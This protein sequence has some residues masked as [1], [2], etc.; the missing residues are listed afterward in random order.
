[1]S[2][3]A[4]S[5]RSTRTARPR[6]RWMQHSLALFC[7][8]LVLA[9]WPAAPTQAQ[10]VPF[11]PA[12]CPIAALEGQ[13]I[14][15]GY[16]TVAE[17]RSNFTGRTIQLA[18][19]IVRSPNPNKAADPAVFLAGGPGQGAL[20]IAPIVARLYGPVLAQRDI[21]FVDQRGT[22]YSRPRLDCP[23]SLMM[24]GGRFPIGVYQDQERSGFVQQQV[25]QFKACGAALRSAGIDLSAY[26][27][28]E[29]A[30]D[31]ED[32]RLALGYGPWNLIGGS[33]GTRLALT[34]M[35]YRPETIRSA[36]LDSVYPLQANFHTEVFGSYNRA[37][38]LLFA[39][40]A[41]DA[42]C[43]A[44]FPNLD[45]AYDDVIARFNAEP[46][47]MPILNPET[48]EVLTTL[49]FT[50][51]DFSLII[52]QLAYSTEVIT[53][54]PALIT[55]TANGNYELMGAL[56]GSLFASQSGVS[57]V[58]AAMQVAV[59]C[60]EDAPFAEPVDFVAARDSN[61]RA[62]SLAHSAL[63][64]EAVLEVC[65][66]WGLTASNPAENRPVVSDRPAL[67]IAGSNDPITPPSYAASAAE[68]L[69]NS[70]LVVYPRG[71]HTPSI[72]SP[73]LTGAIAAFLN[74]P[75]Q[76]PDTS[77]IA[78]EAPLPFLTPR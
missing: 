39:D 55:L 33:Y 43:N 48:G 56:L 18:I 10:T 62:S 23:S 17:S 12:E 25:D 65:A 30:A 36:V 75:S 29:N 78:Q 72:G 51:V 54:L 31:L 44:A 71:G 32:L 40:C 3:L 34:S 35:Q 45:Q 27:T 15:C 24:I 74:D 37:L 19:A 46:V 2:P 59:Q 7:G 73:C 21:I 61:R 67:L 49:P 38:S 66:D 26:N 28:V 47:Q 77:C 14:D 11:T 41:A 22:G 5:L 9:M 69:S 50:G 13:T 76:S 16:L 52:F 68:T 58:A 64:N 57:P 70:T 1:M 6:R 60:N 53:I 63:F 4:L 42:A 8:L 20:D